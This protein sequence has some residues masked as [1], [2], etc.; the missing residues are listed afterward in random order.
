[1]LLKDI[2]SQICPSLLCTVPLCKMIMNPLLFILTS[3]PT[4]VFSCLRRI[5]HGAFGTCPD[6]FLLLTKTACQSVISHLGVL[7]IL[8]GCRSSPCSLPFPSKWEMQ[9]FPLSHISHGINL[10]PTSSE[11]GFVY[12]VSLIQSNSE[13]TAQGA[14]HVATCNTDLTA[15]MPVPAPRQPGNPHP[16]VQPE[17]QEGPMLCVPEG[18]HSIFSHACLT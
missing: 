11:K 17:G 4:C 15:P 1:M 18:V 3:L 2:V 6:I 7:L 13:Q 8:P 12:A 14:V 16:L 9:P 5:L 10:S